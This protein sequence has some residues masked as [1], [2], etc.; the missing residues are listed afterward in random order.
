MAQ[1]V[2]S[3]VAGVDH[4]PLDA[5]GGEEPAS[6]LVATELSPPG[7]VSLGARVRRQVEHR[8]APAADREAKLG[9][10]VRGAGGRRPLGLGEARFEQTTIQRRDRGAVD[11]VVDQRQTINRGAQAVNA[12]ERLWFVR[13]R[14]AHQRTAGQIA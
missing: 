4:E 10:Q 6:H 14:P 7:D 3:L 11:V 12:H 8:G 13:S 5:T 2:P 1:D 9:I